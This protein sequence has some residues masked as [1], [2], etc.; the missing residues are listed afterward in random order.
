MIFDFDGVIAD[1]M[2]FYHQAW[3]EAF[4]EFGL[5]DEI[6]GEGK[7]FSEEMFKEV[8]AREGEKPDIIAREVY[9]KYAKTGPTKFIENKIVQ[10][11]EEIYHKILKLNI[12]P[13]VRE[14]LTR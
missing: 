1:S 11:K 7:D 14:L 5:E 9:R 6:K 2:P 4:R 12:F 13:G 3:M 8:Y 10:I